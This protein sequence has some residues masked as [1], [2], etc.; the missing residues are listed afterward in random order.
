MVYEFRVPK[1]GPPK[2]WAGLVTTLL[3]RFGS[4]IQSQEAQS[5]LMSILQGQRA[6]RNYAS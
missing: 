5:Q 1:R 2:D 3:D 4:N 6:V